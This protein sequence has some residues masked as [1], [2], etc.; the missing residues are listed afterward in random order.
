MV[1]LNLMWYGLDISLLFL[2][3]ISQRSKDSS[4]KSYW[5]LS[6][7]LEIHE[8]LAFVLEIIMIVLDTVANTRLLIL[9]LPVFL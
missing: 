2:A 8:L 3:G 1:N 4:Y 6:K 9:G 5:Q 7:I